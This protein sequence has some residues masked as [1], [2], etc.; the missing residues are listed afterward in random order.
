MVIAPLDRKVLR[1][2][3]RMRSQAFAIA[4]VIAAGVGMVVMSLGM[5]QSLESTREAYYD[6]Y[7]L[8]DV[9]APMKRASKRIAEDIRSIPGVLIAEGRITAGATLDVSGIAEPVTAKIHSL[10]KSGQPRLNALVLRSG[11]FPAADA[12]DEVIISEKFAHAA[13]IGLGDRFWAILYGKRQELRAVGTAIS[14][15]YVYAIGPGQ[16]FPDNRRFG[17]L[18]M[19]EEHLSAALDLTDSVNEVLVRLERGGS[20]REV[21]RRID[22]ILERYGGTSAYPRSEQLSDRF[23]SNELEELRT[24]TGILPPVFLG[25]AAFLI[26]MVLS[27]LIDAEHEVIGLLMAFGYRGRAIM[28]HYT[29]VA[30]ALA[31]PG[32]G[33][34]LALGAWL[35]RG[36]AEIY[37][38][39]FVFPFL[40]FRIDAAVF[41]AASALTLG[42]VLFGVLQSVRRVRQM[43]PVEAM[44]PPLPASYGGRT[45]R[46]LSEMRSLDEPT[47]II[48]RGIVRR[49]FRSAL[50]AL[51]VAAAMGLYI[52]SAG[53][54]DNVARMIDILFDQSNRADMMVVFAE[55]RDERALFALA[56]APGVWRVEPM[57]AIGAKLSFGH[58]SKTE[59][60]TGAMSGGDLFR[61]VGVDGEEIEP[62]THG[63]L[64]SQGLANELAVEPGER[65][66]V[67]I[68]DGERPEFTLPVAGVIESAVG[69]PVYVENATIARLMREAP[70]FSGA[71]L[72][73]DSARID[74]LYHYLK[75]API[76][77]GFSLREAS[78]RGLDETIGETMGI[79][80]LFN[81]GFSALIVFGV[82]YNNA[83]ISLAERA[84]DLATLR[85]LGY[86][87][88][89][90]SYILLGELAIL[91]LLGL[92]GGI[93]F[94]Y[95]LSKWLSGR[96]GGDLFTVP[97]ALSTATVAQA[98]I[99]TMLASL[100]TA[101]FVRRRLDRLDLVAV[102]KS[103]D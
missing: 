17:V 85:V 62:P 98:V 8:A 6:R 3:W 22:L 73:V 52:T 38:D 66:D 18:W 4:L 29:K 30:V 5:I 42:V 11:R 89:E 68:T 37:Q 16:I 53:S 91:T 26:N 69:A 43:T 75:Q 15:E 54:S 87:R 96:L 13:R 33:L 70:L 102:L 86:R 56:R 95:A 46:L 20:S 12:P 65:L 55:P 92:P 47:R 10:P 21:L 82:I 76:V 7:R 80:T 61:P 83:R 27:R 100:I 40:Q 71:Y 28:A 94:G 79:V 51:G 78:R 32:L 1:D 2:L 67:R 36:L 45:A 59:G 49:P 64:I 74:E 39:F 81:T 50:G 60:L 35:G 31:I 88:S 23:L 14:P 90:V 101:L 34:G 25:V 93:A 103:W 41:V 77:A 44:R 24:I 72:G 99:A 97:F 57:R 19:G 63:L 9:Y 84:R 58:R 48:L